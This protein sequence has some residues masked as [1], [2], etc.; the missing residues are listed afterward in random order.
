M[1]P[2]VKFKDVTADFNKHSS[3]AYHQKAQLNQAEQRQC[4]VVQQAC[5]GMRARIKK[6]RQKLVSILQTVV[7]CGRQ[8]IAS[9]GHR[10]DNKSMSKSDVN[11]GNFHAVLLFR[12]DKMEIHVLANTSPKHPRT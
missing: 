12:I 7:L 8:N 10:D 1:S 4:N 11:F 5:R 2:L 6:N 3:K 9:R